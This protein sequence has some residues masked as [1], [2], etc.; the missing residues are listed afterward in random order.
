MISPHSMNDWYHDRL[1]LVLPARSWSSDDAHRVGLI[2]GMLASLVELNSAVNHAASFGFVEVGPSDEPDRALRE[3]FADRCSRLVLAPLIERWDEA[4]RVALTRIAI[5]ENPWAR[6]VGSLLREIVKELVSELG[7][8]FGGPP[9]AAYKVCCT[10]ASG[11]AGVFG[12]LSDETFAFVAK[13][14]LYVLGLGWSD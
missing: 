2:D 13:G 7:Q 1:D 10:G 8:L 14:R 6:E 3:L 9:A 5:D 4:V 12:Y 11:G